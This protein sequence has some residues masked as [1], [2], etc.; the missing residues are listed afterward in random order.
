[1]AKKKSISFTADELRLLS[2]VIG[3]GYGDGDIYQD[4]WID[5]KKDQRIFEQAWAKIDRAY[6]I[7]K[8]NP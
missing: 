3:N 5:T 7:L 8:T 6:H 1:M 2:F 4:G